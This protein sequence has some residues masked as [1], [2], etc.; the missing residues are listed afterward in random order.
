MWAG[1]PGACTPWRVFR[2][3]LRRTRIDDDLYVSQGLY[4]SAQ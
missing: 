3:L 2:T 1:L 4:I